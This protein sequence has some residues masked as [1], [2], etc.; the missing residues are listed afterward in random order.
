[1]FYSTSG[2]NKTSVELHRDGGSANS[3]GCVCKLLGSGQL[4][5]CYQSVW[6]L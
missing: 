5:W 6:S 2:N 1:L 4:N 3:T